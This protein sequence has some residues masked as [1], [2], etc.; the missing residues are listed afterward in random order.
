[1]GH[2]QKVAEETIWGT[3]KRLLKRLYGAL[4]KGCSRDC[5]GHCQKVAQETIW[6]TVKRLLKRR[7]HCQK[8]A[9][10]TVWGNYKVT[11]VNVKGN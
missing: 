5:M 3:V 10:E 1:M 7:G 4:S 9:K 6:G 8:A 2:C 11:E